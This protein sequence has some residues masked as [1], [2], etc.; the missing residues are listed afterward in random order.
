MKI[1]SMQEL[2]KMYGLSKVAIAKSLTKHQHEINESATRNVWQEGSKNEWRLTEDGR[3][4]WDKVRTAKKGSVAPVVVIQGNDE[5]VSELTNEVSTLKTTLLLTQNRLEQEKDKRI[6]LLEEKT[7]AVKSLVEAESS[8]KIA[9]AESKQKDERIEA[10]EDEK[11]AN[12][13]R[14]MSAEAEVARYKSLNFLERLIFLIK[15][16]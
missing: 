16:Q 8:R 3:Q 2:V 7:E 14:A 13:M 11:Q 1:Y 5:R 15:G 4:I 6:K 12:L 10:L 9:E